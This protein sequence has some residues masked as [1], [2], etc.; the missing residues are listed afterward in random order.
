M[1]LREAS[2][3][4]LGFFI[5]FCS[6]FFGGLFL[7]LFWFVGWLGFLR[8]NVGVS[9]CGFLVNIRYLKLPFF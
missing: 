4:S 5:S 8:G 6:L 1:A 9:F 2:E 3:M 7:W